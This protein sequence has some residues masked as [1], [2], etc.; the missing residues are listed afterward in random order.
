MLSVLLISTLLA[1]N[2]LAA[3]TGCDMT[4]NSDL[5][6]CLGNYASVPPV[7]TATA[8]QEQ[9]AELCTIY[10]QLANC[11]AEG[12]YCREWLPMQTAA[13]KLCALASMG[14]MGASTTSADAT[15]TLS[16]TSTDLTSTGSPSALASSASSS[17]LPNATAVTASNPSDAS[18]IT[19]APP[20]S[21]A[22]ASSS[23]IVSA[24]PESVIAEASQVLTSVW[25][26]DS[27]TDIPVISND[28]GTKTE[29]TWTKAGETSP[30][31][32]NP[33]SAASGTVGGGS[34]GSSA[35]MKSVKPSTLGF[36]AVGLFVVA[37]LWWA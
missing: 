19:S 17:L 26:N 29:P 34:G 1:F 15:S 36:G 7:P 4:P 22:S 16:N 2:A 24:T 10:T 33:A 9:A 23:E 14:F 18:T 6:K 20:S 31:Q 27:G 35:A 32:T 21:T 12:T 13:D 11:W 8:S 25:N 3:D 30:G 5:M 28:V 37:S